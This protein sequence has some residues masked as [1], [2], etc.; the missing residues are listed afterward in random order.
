MPDINTLYDTLLKKELV[1]R[2]GREPFAN[3]LINADND[4]DLVNEILWQLIVQLSTLHSVNATNISAIE[5]AVTPISTE[6]KKLSPKSAIPLIQLQKAT[7]LQEEA[8]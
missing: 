7:P 2:M 4:S 1:R 6:V 5:A 3:E 8:L